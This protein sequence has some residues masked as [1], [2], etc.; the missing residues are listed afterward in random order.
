MP[1]MRTLLISLILLTSSAQ[2]AMQNQYALVFFFESTCPYCHK[3]APKVTQVSLTAQLPVYAFSVDGQGI[4]GFEAPIPV[5]PEIAGTFFP[6]GGKAV[7]PSTFL[8]NVNSRKFTRI[9][10]GDIPQSTLLQ[11][12]QNAIRDPRVQEA[13]Q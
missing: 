13:L 11:S 3:L 6:S 5:T 7:M 8:I 10:I 9:S 2:A 12:V 1:F 4:P